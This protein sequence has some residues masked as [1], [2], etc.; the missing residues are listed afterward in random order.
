LFYRR[1]GDISSVVPGEE[2]LGKALAYLPNKRH[3]FT[4]Y[5]ALEIKKEKRGSHV[6]V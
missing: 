1:H 5:L 2:S 6:G 3:Q 4:V